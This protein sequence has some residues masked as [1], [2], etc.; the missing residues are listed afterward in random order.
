MPIIGWSKILDKLVFNS[1]SY[2]A[3]PSSFMIRNQYGFTPNKD[4]DHGL[5]ELEDTIK[6]CHERGN[7]Y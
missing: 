3:H 4:S 5:K 6:E 2:Y 1:L 7:D